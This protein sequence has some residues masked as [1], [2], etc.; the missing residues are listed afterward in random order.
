MVNNSGNRAKFAFF[1]R[2]LKMAS[3]STVQQLK[4]N[5]QSI[6]L[7]KKKEIIQE[8]E[9]RS[10]VQKVN[11]T[12]LA[13]F[14][15]I[16]HSTLLTILKRKETIQAACQSAEQNKTKLRKQTNISSF[17]FFEIN[18]LAVM[19][20]KIICFFSFHYCLLL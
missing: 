20:L 8:Y 3:S 5:R 19:P 13:E 14:F 2:T 17:F 15:L 6:S 7:K 10:L 16:P 11:K 12:K 4:R 1:L 9:R 18:D